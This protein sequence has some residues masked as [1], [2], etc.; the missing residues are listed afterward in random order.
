MGIR[1]LVA[2]GVIAIILASLFLLQ[3]I[4]LSSVDTPPPYFF[5]W[6]LEIVEENKSTVVLEIENVSVSAH[7]GKGFVDITNL[8]SIPLTSLLILLQ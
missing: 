1:G 5:L 8:T 7:R 4:A 6:E 3:G 2:V